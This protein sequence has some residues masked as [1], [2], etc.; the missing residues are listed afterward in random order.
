[1]DRGW[2]SFA[3]VGRVLEHLDDLWTCYNV[4]H[5]TWSLPIADNTGIS[6]DII[7]LLLS[8]MRIGLVLRPTRAVFS[9]LD[10]A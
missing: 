8:S 9:H 7:I 10:L 5:L 1:M 3:V 6:N 2:L 4:H